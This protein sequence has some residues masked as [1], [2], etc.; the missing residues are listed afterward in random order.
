MTYEVFKTLNLDTL[1]DGHTK[2]CECAIIK[3]I[4]LHFQLQ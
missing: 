3:L 4:G 1:E 2:V